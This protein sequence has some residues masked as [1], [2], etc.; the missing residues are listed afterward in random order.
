M[1]DKPLRP[2]HESIIDAIRT[3]S[4]SDLLCLA[5]LIKH[6]FIPANHEAIITSWQ[7][8]TDNI[9]VSRYGVTEY[10]LESKQFIETRQQQEMDGFEQLLSDF[11]TLARKHFGEHYRG[12]IKPANTPKAETAPTV[13]DAIS[14]DC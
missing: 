4:I 3:A 13:G 8:R 6:T 1:S 14:F 9:S 2:F 7:E 10:L 12:A 5:T 11:D